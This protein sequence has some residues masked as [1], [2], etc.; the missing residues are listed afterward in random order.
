M[1]FAERQLVI[2]L[3]EHLSWLEELIVNI[4]DV[5][6]GKETISDVSDISEMARSLVK[7][8]RALEFSFACTV[9]KKLKLDAISQDDLK[10][11]DEKWREAE[12]QKSRE[13]RKPQAT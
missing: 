5:T 6:V 1:L 10:T 11:E 9:R 2:K 8:L 3:R 7:S 12:D 13:K 4:R